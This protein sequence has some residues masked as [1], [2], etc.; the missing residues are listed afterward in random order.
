MLSEGYYEWQTTQGE[1]NKQPFYLYQEIPDNDDK[2]WKEKSLVKFAGLFNKTLLDGEV[3]Y[4][5]TILTKESDG[6]MSWMHHRMP[7]ILNSRQEVED[8]L[9]Y[10]DVNDR[11]AVEKLRSLKSD[12]KYEVK[13]YMVDKS[14]NKSTFDDK[15]CMERAGEKLS[16]ARLI[17]CT[18]AAFKLY[19]TLMCCICT[20]MG[21]MRFLCVISKFLDISALAFVRSGGVSRMLSRSI[22]RWR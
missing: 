5:C 20:L 18:T 11:D 13:Y 3:R 22:L 7:V 17:I 21:C 4:S 14:V 16:I 2:P 8:W 10:R 19:T 6:T 1:N 9:N 15:K 12:P